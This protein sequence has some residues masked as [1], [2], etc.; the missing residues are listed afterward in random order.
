MAISKPKELN[1]LERIIHS[2][3]LLYCRCRFGHDIRLIPLSRYKF[4]IVDAAD[5]GQLKN[6]N[7]RARRS[8]HTW[9]AFRLAL[10]A[11]KRDKN[12]VWIHNEI[13]ENPNGLLIDHFNRNGL[14]NRRTNLRL[15]TRAQNTCNCKKRKGCSSRFK[16][17]CFHKNSRRQNPW[18]SYI[19]VNGQRISLGCYMTEVEAAKVYDRAAR[20]YHKEFAQL[21]FP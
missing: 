16:G 7:W 11:E 12:L 14:D 6:F 3:Y 10:V 15:A 18:D 17:V 2:A 9:Y 8:L 5:Y 19:N 4:A 21:N 1:W 13:I 20:E